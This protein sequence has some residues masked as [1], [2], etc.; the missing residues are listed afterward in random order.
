[1]SVTVY[2]VG[3]SNHSLERFLALLEAHGVATLVDVRSVPWSRRWPWFRRRPLAA[4]AAVAGLGYHFLGEHL[5][6]RPAVPGRTPGFDAGVARVL[7]LAAEGRTALLCAEADPA[8]CH[9]A[10][11]LA[12]ALLAR[13]ARVRHLLAGGGAQ[14]HTVLMERLAV[15]PVLRDLFEG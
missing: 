14:D 8:R 9:R 7:A 13:G 1:V 2:T 10:G 11:L 6:G 12:P 15:A 5:G 4:S 3:H